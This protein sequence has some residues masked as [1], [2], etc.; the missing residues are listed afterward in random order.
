MI[1]NV[2]PHGQILNCWKPIVLPY[3]A[4]AVPTVINSFRFKQ[5]FFSFVCLLIDISS[6]DGV[7]M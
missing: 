4:R 3:N 6:G 5:F 1:R 2:T 7:D